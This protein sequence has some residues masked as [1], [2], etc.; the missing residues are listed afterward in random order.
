MLEVQCICDCSLDAIF[1]QSSATTPVVFILSPGSDPTA[2][3]MKLADRQGAGG[4]QFKYLSLGQ[5]QEKVKFL[6]EQAELT[7]INIK[8]RNMLDVNIIKIKYI[9]ELYSLTHV[10]SFT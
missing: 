10:T 5:G 1:D 4:T 6:T 9:L 8:N 3:L 2:D 7:V